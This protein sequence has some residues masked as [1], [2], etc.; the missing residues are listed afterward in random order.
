MMHCAGL[1]GFRALLS[2][3]IIAEPPPALPSR[4]LSRNLSL[5][6]TAALGLCAQLQILDLSYCTK[7]EALTEGDPTPNPDPNPDPDPNQ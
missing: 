3:V 1:R 2:C 7:L 6:L 5:T 4:N